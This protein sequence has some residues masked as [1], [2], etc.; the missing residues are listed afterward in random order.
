MGL[1]PT[2]QNS[3]G[4]IFQVER[5]FVKETGDSSGLEIYYTNFIYQHFETGYLY[6]RN[7]HYGGCAF[8]VDICRTGNLSIKLVKAPPIHT[9]F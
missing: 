9:H 8:C 5:T 2:N 4:A 6:S 1:P 3:L 7:I